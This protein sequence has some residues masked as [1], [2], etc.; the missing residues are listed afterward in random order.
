MK[1][2][3][4][5]AAFALAV[6]VGVA[7]FCYRIWEGSTTYESAVCSITV[8]KPDYINAGGI[9]EYNIDVTVRLK[10]FGNQQPAG[11]NTWIVVINHES[12]IWAIDRAKNVR[13][14][15]NGEGKIQFPLNSSWTQIGYRR[16]TVMV[17]PDGYP[18][19]QLSFVTY[20][21]H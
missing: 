7:F 5:R 12:D 18:P 20:S 11:I 19:S 2:C 4:L 8:G 13:M 17:L 15:Q 10:P 6:F 16:F 14:D 3:L 21:D 1:S 9:G